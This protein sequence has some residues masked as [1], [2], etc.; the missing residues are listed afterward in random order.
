MS[1]SNK[2]LLTVAIVL[3]VLLV[4]LVVLTVLR[5]SKKVDRND[6]QEI[7]ATVD[8]ELQEQDQIEQERVIYVPYKRDS[9]S[10]TIENETQIDSAVGDT[11]NIAELIQED[12]EFPAYSREVI[13]YI[14]K[15]FQS[16]TPEEFYPGNE[17][18]GDFISMK[19]LRD[20]ALMR[21]ACVEYGLQN[22]TVLETAESGEKYGLT[23]GNACALVKAELGEEYIVFTDLFGEYG[24]VT[25]YPIISLDGRVLI[26]SNYSEE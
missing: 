22:Y 7:V 17:V 16:S 24:Y 20:A 2:R 23:S 26:N 5:K 19:D 8:P 4:I 11:I 25:S 10:T 21:H 3:F 6:D 9:E 12:D 13:Q 1:K 18:L 15:V 14:G